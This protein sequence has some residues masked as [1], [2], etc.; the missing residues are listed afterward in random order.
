MNFKNLPTY[1]ELKMKKH[2]HETVFNV[3]FS[4]VG[5]VVALMLLLAYF[6]VL[7]K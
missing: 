7:V 4:I 1:G 2:F 3:T 6:D 5:F